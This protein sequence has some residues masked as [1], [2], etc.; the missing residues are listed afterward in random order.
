MKNNLKKDFTGCKPVKVVLLADSASQHLSIAIK[1]FGF[2]RGIQFEVLEAGYDE[3]EQQVFDK[4]SE[5]YSFEPQ[6]IIISKSPYKLLSQFYSTDVRDRATFAQKNIEQINVILSTL[7]HNTPANIIFLNFEEINDGVFGNY[8]AKINTSFL[9]QIRK[10]N[11]LLMEE[12]QAQPSLFICDVQ[13][14]I[15]QCG[16]QNAVDRKNLVNADLLWSLEFIPALAKNIVAIVEA[17]TGTFKKCLVLDL[18]NTIWGGVIGDDG[19]EGIQIGDLGIGKAFTQLQQWIKELGRRGIIICVCSKNTESIAMEVFTTHPDM[20]LKAE[21]I[22]VFAVNWENKVDNLYYIKNTLNIG[23]DSMVFL[24]DNPFEREMVK[25]AMPE[26]E[27]PHLSED[28]AEYLPYLQSLNLFETASYTEEDGERTALYKQE[29]R[30]T[31][32]QLVYKNEEDYLRELEMKAEILPLN[33]FTIPRAAQLS[34]RS[35]QFNLRTVRY[36]ET[37]L[38]DVAHAAN[39]FSFV[40]SLKDKFGSYGIISLVVLRKTSYEELFIDTWLMSCRV[41]KRTVESFILNQ[42]ISLAKGANCKSVVG[43]YIPTTKNELVKHHYQNLGF[44]TKNGLWYLDAVNYITKNNFV[45]GCSQ[46]ADETV[47]RQLHKEIL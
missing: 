29:A 17:T 40:L 21:D 33:S 39:H 30:R 45:T 32:F 23:F 18:D 3:I 1:G 42:I 12:A 5:L 37:E 6:T 26:I 35:N 38:T 31:H 28:P 8:A 9:Y 41:L 14:L 34:Q 43:E 44:E 27:V 7:Q 36:T 11:L 15:T 4:G 25:A 19:I 10:L 2:E 16:S 46:L 24:D 22:A 13:S 47:T 20:I